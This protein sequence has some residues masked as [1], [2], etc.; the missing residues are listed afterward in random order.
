MC[1]A[2]STPLR[3][4]T[5]P[6]T[7]IDA[8][9]TTFHFTTP[10]VPDRLQDSIRV[11]GITHP[12]LLEPVGSGYRIIAGFKRYQVAGQAAMNRVPAWVAAGGAETAELARLAIL[13]NA[14]DY[15]LMEK[16]RALRMLRDAAVRRTRM[17]TEFL[18]LLGIEPQGHYLEAHLALLNLSES[19]FRFLEDIPVTLRQAERL[20]LLPAGEQE[21]VV[22]AAKRFHWRGFEL[23]H[24]LA[25]LV[26]I[27]RRDGVTTSRV[28]GAALE[29]VG[30]RGGPGWREEGGKLRQYLS[31]RRFPE[32]SRVNE[33]LRGL[34]D[35]IDLGC[36]VRIS[37][38]DTLERPGIEVSVKVRYVQDLSRI[39]AGW[40]RP[41]NRGWIRRM[42]DRI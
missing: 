41:S 39:S 28:L 3:W 30:E 42:L 8:D 20:C 12:L 34:A 16:A 15:H 37:W 21:Q 17:V 14:R 11:M 18:P 31:E 9:D 6:R 19:S 33:A 25:D 38:D 26:E 35:R 1:Q 2:Q 36:P 5:V 24:I 22:A 29:R 23:Q 4:A 27:A 32:R 7:D 40:S 10:T 13:D